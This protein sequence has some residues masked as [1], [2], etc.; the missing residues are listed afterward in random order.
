MDIKYRNASMIMKLLMLD[1]YI[2]EEPKEILYNIL[3]AGD[4]M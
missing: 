4:S 1:L 2:C 3:Y